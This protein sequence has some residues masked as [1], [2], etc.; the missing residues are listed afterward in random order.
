[1]RSMTVTGISSQ[2]RPFNSRP[3]AAF[4]RF[5]SV[6]AP[7]APLLEEK[8]DSLLLALCPN[9]LCPF[10]LHWARLRARLTTHNHPMNVRQVELTNIGQ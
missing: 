1:M 7:S 3:L 8:G 4:A 10:H 5:F 6:C 2:V 9:G